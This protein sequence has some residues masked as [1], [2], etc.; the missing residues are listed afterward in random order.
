MAIVELGAGCTYRV[1]LHNESVGTGMV[2]VTEINPEIIFTE[3][4]TRA[5]NCLVCATRI[6]N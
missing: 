6:K 2:H 4:K 3:I 1:N 5:L